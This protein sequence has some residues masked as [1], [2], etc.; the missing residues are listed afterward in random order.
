M[1]GVSCD[2]VASAANAGAG[3]TG[4]GLTGAGIACAEEVVA[5][6]GIG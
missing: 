2:V 6:V 5:A 3:V 4:A 1:R